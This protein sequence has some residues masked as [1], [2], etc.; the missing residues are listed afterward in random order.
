MVRLNQLA[1]QASKVKQRQLATAIKRAR[2]LA[3]C[4]LLHKDICIS[5]LIEKR[6]VV[7][8]VDGAIPNVIDYNQK[9]MGRGGSIVNVA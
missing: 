5:Q 6:G 9:V 3:S 1:K 7:C 2:H 4:H 8:Q